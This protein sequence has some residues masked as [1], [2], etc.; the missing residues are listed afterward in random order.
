MHIFFEG[1]KKHPI[2]NVSSILITIFIFYAYLTMPGDIKP[3]PKTP[4]EIQL[5]KQKAL[6]DERG[7]R[8]DKASASGKTV[9]EFLKSTITGK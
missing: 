3:L 9:H 2:L 5:E 7:K 6:E 1:I 8:N 4:E